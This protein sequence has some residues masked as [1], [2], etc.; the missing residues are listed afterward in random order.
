M[1]NG[2]Y[3]T[4][5]R[6]YHLCSIEVPLTC[7][8]LVIRRK[9]NMVPLDR[10]VSEVFAVAKQPLSPGDTLEGIGGSHFYSLIDR[11]DVAQRERLLPVGLAKDARLIRP[12][13]RDQPITYDDVELHEPSTILDLRRLQDAWMAGSITDDALASSMDAMADG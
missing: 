2:P 11:Y 3:Y 13:P 4:L 6:P 1:G 7:A 5:F 8:M 10:L 12:V 9:S